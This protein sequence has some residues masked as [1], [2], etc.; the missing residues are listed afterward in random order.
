MPIDLRLDPAEVALFTDL[1]ELTVSAAFFEHG[2]NDAASFEVAMR[3]MPPGRGFMVAAGIERLI[4]AL[5]DYRFDAAAIEHLDSL[6]LFKPA[7]LEFLSQL[8]FTGSIRAL[9]EGTIYFPGEPIA[10]IRAPLIEGQLIETLALNQLGFASIVATKAARC[11]AVAGGRRLVDFG[12]RRA[13]GL[14]A[15]LIAARSSYMAGFHG[16]ANVLAGRRYGIPVFGTMSHSFVMAHEREREAFSDFVASFPTLST[17][18]V[19]TY[20]TVRGMENAAGATA[21]VRAPGVKIQGVR[22]DS[23]DLHDLSRKAR[24]ILDQAG[25]GDVAIVASGNLDEYKI[26]DLVDGGAPIDAFGVGTALAVSDDAPAGDFT[27]KL[28]EYKDRARLKTSA[29]K[30]STPGRK[31]LFRGYAPSGSFFADMVG[32]VD[33]GTTTVGREF[34]PIPS[35][36]VQ[37]LEPVFANGRR[38]MP[39]PTLAEARER[40]M[41]GLI[42]LDARYK[43]LRRPAEFPVR[44]TAAL[45]ALVISEKL[46]AQKRQD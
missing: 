23:G 13:Q 27:Y 12:P 2:F 25:L 19:D 45:G 9:P 18:L 11:F 26:A 41:T 30:I 7:F 32:I 39:R 44:Q 46:R 3:R 38:I 29:G 22:L 8:R 6:R 28:V 4:E 20:D 34:K 40:V 37:L 35:K 31:Q 33:E 21:E 5:E 17:L 24:R 16:T 10:E 36:T 15:S 43:T 1:Y 14:D 42:T